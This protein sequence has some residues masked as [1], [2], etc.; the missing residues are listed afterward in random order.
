MRDN[1]N[2]YVYVYASSL[3]QGDASLV[4]RFGLLLLF[5]P[6]SSRTNYLA[7]SLLNSSCI[8]VH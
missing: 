1:W 6:M 4:T 3:E 7:N 2:Y 5:S 8:S